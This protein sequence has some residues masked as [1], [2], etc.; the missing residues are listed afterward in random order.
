MPSYASRIVPDDRWRIAAYIRVLQFSE[1][2]T[3]D[4]V[5]ADKRVEIDKGVATPQLSALAPSPAEPTKQEKA[6]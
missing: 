3:I 4:D 1:N 5:P 2:A 6:K